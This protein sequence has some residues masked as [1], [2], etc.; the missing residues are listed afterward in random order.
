MKPSPFRGPRLRVLF[1]QLA[2]LW[3]HPLRRLRR[4]GSLALHRWRVFGR[5]SVPRVDI[6]E[7]PTPAPRLPHPALLVESAPE[8]LAAARRWLAGQT[9]GSAVMATTGGT[10]AGTNGDT[11]SHAAA[12]IFPFVPGVETLPPTLLESLLLA[13]A[14]LDP[15]WIETGWASPSPELEPTGQLRSPAA[16]PI[17]MLRSP[18]APKRKSAAVLRSRAIPHITE[19]R[20]E[21]V[22]SPRATLARKSTGPWGLAPDLVGTPIVS[23]PWH[24]P[25]QRL[26]ELPPIPGPPTVLFLLPFL[27]VGGAERLL[28][29]LI[30]GLGDARVLV[31]TLEPHRAHLGQTVETCRRLTP[32]VHTLGDWLPRPAHDGAIRHLLRRYQVASLVSWNGTV[33]FYDAVAS[34]RR[35]FPELRILHQLYHHTGAWTDRCGPRVARAI[36]C[37]LAVNRAIVDGLGAR[38]ISEDSIELVHHGVEVPPLPTEDQRRRARREAHAILGLPPDLPADRPVV[39][40]FIRLHPQKRPLDVLAVARRR[41]DCHFLLVGGGPLDG[42][43][44]AEL[45]Q[46]PIPNLTR[47]PLRR[48]LETLYAAVDLCLSTSSYEG[49][50]VFLLDGLARA[51]PCVSTAVGEIPELLATGGGE[52]VESV[53]DIDALAAAVARLS[54]PET[55]HREGL[56]GRRTVEEHF[57]LGPYRQRYRRVII[58]QPRAGG[59]NNG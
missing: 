45:E 27:A 47:L 32:H 13:A 28:Y 33:L 3:R 17:L 1:W 49:L 16:P 8:D 51:I 10:T 50:P 6:P 15:P 29:D 34:W 40:T 30:P 53:G 9:E 46:H 23:T 38:G 56:A 11:G 55:R 12:W 26:A 59:E 48:D 43:I 2:P 22:P 18:T 36:D 39:G 42:V 19:P 7:K 41:P 4:L 14:T 31:V 24:D 52:L 21:D 54:D 35:S 5:G 44:D 58:G 25:A 57:A 37:H 20:A